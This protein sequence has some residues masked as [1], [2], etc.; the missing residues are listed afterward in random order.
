[1]TQD[2]LDQLNTTQEV[3]RGLMQ[4]L[5]IASGVNTLDLARL[6]KAS[7]QHTGLSPM[8]QQM[9]QDLACGAETLPQTKSRPE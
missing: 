9:L 4:S 1:M 5:A 2:Q 3:L 6:L 7:A 8:A